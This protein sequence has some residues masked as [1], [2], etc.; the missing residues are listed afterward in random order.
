MYHGKG[1]AMHKSRLMN[2]DVVFTSYETV[3]SDFIR[4]KTL[5]EVSWFRV[6]LDE[7]MQ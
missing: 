6:V 5:Q 2:C 7:G 3:L 4:S 1:T